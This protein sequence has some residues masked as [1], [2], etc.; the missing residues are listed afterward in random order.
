MVNN[1]NEST[2]VDTGT[3]SGRQYLRVPTHPV[4]WVHRN[5]D[6]ETEFWA[7]YRPGNQDRGFVRIGNYEPAGEFELIHHHK[8]VHTAE[9]FRN[10]VAWWYIENN[11]ELLNGYLRSYEFRPSGVGDADIFEGLF[12]TG[13][14]AVNQ[15]NGDHPNDEVAWVLREQPQKA[16]EYWL[17]R[18][19][20]APY[21]APNATDYPNAQFRFT[22]LPSAVDTEPELEAYALAKAGAGNYV[23]HPANIFKAP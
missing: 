9:S 18:T 11:I 5:K 17:L 23:V 13:A 16:K 4:M 7:L 8:M 21:K 1:G 12:D 2:Q 15:L 22:R 6:S 3:F 19:S 10:W 14:Y 20:G